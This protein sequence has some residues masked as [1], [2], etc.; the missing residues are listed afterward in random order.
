MDREHLNEDIIDLGAI[1]LETKGAFGVPEDT[2]A[3]LIPPAGLNA[4]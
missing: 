4:E 1:S 3:G 2:Q